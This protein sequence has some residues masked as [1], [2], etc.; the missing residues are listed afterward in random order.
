[1]SRALKAGTKTLLAK[2]SSRQGGV[3]EDEDKLNTKKIHK[4]SRNEISRQISQSH[5]QI[6]LR[7]LWQVI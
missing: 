6:Y 2:I 1:M 5:E 4:N 3:K 7:R